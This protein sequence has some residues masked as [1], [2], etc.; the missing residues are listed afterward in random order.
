MAETI[1][2]GTIASVNIVEGDSAN[3]HWIRQDC[4]II[5]EYSKYPVHF[6]AMGSNWD[7][8]CKFVQGQQYVVK[9]YLKSTKGTDRNG[10]PMW[11]DKFICSD[12]LTELH[13]QYYEDCMYK[14]RDRHFEQNYQMETQRRY[15]AA[16]QPQ[17]Y[18]QQ[19]QMYQPA[20][21]PQGYD[22]QYTAQQQPY[23]QPVQGNQS[24]LP[25]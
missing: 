11:F 6:Q 19:A 13:N 23:R 9:L 5:P 15:A 10:Q 21:Q 2:K 12:T 25:F 4:V 24:N 1:I 16:S 7:D 22:N 3:G 18:V 8:M 17:G 14:L 20:Q